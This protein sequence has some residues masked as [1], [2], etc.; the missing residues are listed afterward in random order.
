MVDVLEPGHVFTV[1]PGLYYPDKGWGM[2]IEDV[3]YVHEDGTMEN[4]TKFPKELV[5][6]L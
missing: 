5:V 6:E 3:V 2:R 1:E 4:L